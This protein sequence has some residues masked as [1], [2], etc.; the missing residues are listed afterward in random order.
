VEENCGKKIAGW[1]GNMLSIGDR[2]TLIN[3]CL[4]SIALYILSF[5]EAPKGFINKE[6]MHRNCGKKETLS[7][8][9]RTTR[10]CDCMHCC[11]GSYG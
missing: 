11:D 3:A 7:P 10:G 5:L 9:K 4:S 8:P 6:D 1:K 2:V